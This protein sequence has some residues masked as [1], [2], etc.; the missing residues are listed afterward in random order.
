MLFIIRYHFLI[1]ITLPSLLALVLKKYLKCLQYTFVSFANII[2]SA[3]FKKA[4]NSANF[5]ILIT[6]FSVSSYD[7]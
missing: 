6:I 4:S 1:K 2:N 3:Q 5:N 7:S